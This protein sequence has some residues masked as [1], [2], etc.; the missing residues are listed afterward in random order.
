LPLQFR[1]TKTKVR[2]GSNS[3]AMWAILA[4]FADL[5]TRLPSLRARLCHQALAC[6]VDI[7]QCQGRER[8]RRIFLQAT[9]PHLAK[10]P[11]ALDNAKDMFDVK[12]D[13]GLVEL[14]TS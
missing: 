11:Q 4:L 2:S 14:Q 13:A 5:S 3:H 7:C 12:S 6:E 10:G 1:D 8:P 9:I